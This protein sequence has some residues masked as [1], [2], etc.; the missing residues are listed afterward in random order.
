MIDKRRIVR[1]IGE[2]EPEYV[3]HMDTTMRQMLA[4]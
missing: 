3:T 4:L 2:L 1:I